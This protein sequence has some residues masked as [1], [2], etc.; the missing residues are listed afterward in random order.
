MEIICYC[1]GR[2]EN[3]ENTI[4]G[5]RHCLSVNPSWRIEMD[6]QMTADKKLVLHHDYNT[7]RTTGKNHE[8]NQLPLLEVKQLNAG[9]NFQVG[10][11]FPYRTDPVRVPELSDVFREFPDA[12]LLLD[13]HTNDPKVTEIFM[14][15]VD[16]EFNQGDFIVVSEYDEVIKKLRKEK[17][18][19]RY[20]VPTLEAKKMLYGSFVYLDGLFPIKSDILMLPKKYGKINVLSKRVIRHAKKRNKPIWAWLYEGDHVRTIE[21]KSQMDEL[22]SLGIDGIF[23]GFPRKLFEEINAAI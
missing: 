10:E 1:C 19:W 11:A 4:E 8:I 14:G 6:I 21:S 5:I 13:I 3:P 2:G 12:K 16:S 22:R 17:P 9:Y 15:L 20:G 7:I 18:H 23:T